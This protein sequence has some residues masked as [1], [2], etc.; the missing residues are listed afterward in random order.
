MD[1]LTKDQILKANDVEF[2]DVDMKDFGWPGK[3]RVGVMSGTARDSFE[4]KMFGEDG[5]SKNFENM[6]AKLL[7]ATLIDPESGKELFT[8]EEDVIALGRKSSKALD[9]LFDVARKLNGVLADSEIDRKAK[10]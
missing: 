8:S 1:F 6:R 9:H 3:V 4:L 2:K 10:N 7:A 5:K